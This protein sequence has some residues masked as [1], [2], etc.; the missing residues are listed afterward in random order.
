M[1]KTFLLTL[2]VLALVVASCSGGQEQ[3]SEAM[4][5]KAVTLK[6]TNVVVHYN[7]PATLRGLQDVAI[8]PQ[9]SGRIVKVL[10]KEGQKVDVNQVLF[11]IDDVTYRSAFEAAQADLEMTK[12]GV[13]T[14]KLTFES[15]THLFERNVISEY[16]LKLAKNDLLTAKAARSQAEARLR[17]A[18]NDLSFCQVRTMFAGNVGN[19]PYKIGSL[20]SSAISEPLTVISDNSKVF[21]DFS[22]PENLYLEIA[23]VR[24]QNGFDSDNLPDVKLGMITNDG[25]LYEHQGELYS[26]SGLISQNTGALPVRSLFPNPDGALLSGGSCQVVFSQEENNVILV[27]RTAMKEIQNMLFVYRIVDG[28]TEMTAVKAYRFDDH[29]WIIMRNDDG[30]YPLKDGDVIAASTNR[31]VDAM[32]VEIMQ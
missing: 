5:V 2:S 11:Q 19:L 31:L 6:D 27:P 17:S 29:R 7:F 8:Y 32:E 9:I 30:E 15:K 25:K 28:K 23:E 13:E 12:A 16:Q 21:A 22:I 1:K 10:V 14:A 18:S 26:M 20:V 24:K 4:P 3:G